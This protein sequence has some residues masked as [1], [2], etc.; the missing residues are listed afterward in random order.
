MTV[1]MYKQYPDGTMSHHIARHTTEVMRLE[2]MGY[3]R[4]PEREPSSPTPMT[5]F[6]I[7][8]STADF[9]WS[10]MVIRNNQCN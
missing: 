10:L 7:G 8:D 3:K 9:F 4:T 5:S 1:L 2:S 6:Q